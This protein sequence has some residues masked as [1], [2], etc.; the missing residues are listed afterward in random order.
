MVDTGYRYN[1]CTYTAYPTMERN[2]FSADEFMDLLISLDIFYL[3][4]TWYAPKKSKQIRPYFPRRM[5]QKSFTGVRFRIGGSK[6]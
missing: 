6:K 5:Y 3:R 4:L 1:S 2:R